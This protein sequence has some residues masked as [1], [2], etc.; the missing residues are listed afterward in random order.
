MSV[1][2]DQVSFDLPRPARIPAYLEKT[3]WWA[4]VHPKAVRFLNGNGW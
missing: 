2:A 4:Y 1:E 3:Y